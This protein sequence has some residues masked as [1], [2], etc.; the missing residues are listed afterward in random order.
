MRQNSH[1]VS[2][3][4]HVRPQTRRGECLFSATLFGDDQSPSIFSRV[5]KEGAEGMEWGCFVHLQARCYPVLSQDQQSNIFSSWLGCEIPGIKTNP[6]PRRMTSRWTVFKIST[7]FFLNGNL[8]AGLM[9]EI[10]HHTFSKCLT[11]INIGGL[12]LLISHSYGLV[13][14]THGLWLEMQRSQLNKVTLETGGLTTELL[15]IVSHPLRVASLVK[16][17]VVSTWSRKVIGQHKILT[18]A[19][20]KEAYLVGLTPVKRV[21]GWSSLPQW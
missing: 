1:R 15:F 19:R 6:L 12:S 2:F 7:V 20:L 9:E 10:C 13:V 17:L 5:R 8:L 16:M 3:V 21:A 4:A 14:N 11:A 18:K